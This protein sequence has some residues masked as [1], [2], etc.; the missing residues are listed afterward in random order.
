MKAR[1]NPESSRG[2]QQSRSF[3]GNAGLRSGVDKN[4]PKTGKQT[5]AGKNGRVRGRPPCHRGEIQR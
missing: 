2:G 3:P 4:V 5:V 1:A